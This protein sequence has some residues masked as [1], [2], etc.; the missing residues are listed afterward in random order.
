MA[1]AAGGGHRPRIKTTDTPIRSSEPT[2][3]L[4]SL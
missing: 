1:R 4:K 2:I 3:K